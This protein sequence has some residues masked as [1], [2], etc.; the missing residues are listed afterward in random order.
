M[1]PD[2][3]KFTT[4]ENGAQYVILSGELMMPRLHVVNLVMFLRWKLYKDLKS[5]MAQDVYGCLMCFALE[6]SKVLLNVLI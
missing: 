5:L 4:Q 1:A 2:V 3:W 6:M